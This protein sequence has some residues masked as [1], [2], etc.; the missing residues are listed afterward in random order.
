MNVLLK[1]TNR[2]LRKQIMHLCGKTMKIKV[3]ID[4]NKMGP[5]TIT[6]QMQISEY[7]GRL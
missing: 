6:A 3:K 5:S 7:K 4:N 1:Y 2:K